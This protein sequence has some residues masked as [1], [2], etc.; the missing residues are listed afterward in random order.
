M[1]AYANPGDVILFDTPQATSDFKYANPTPLFPSHTT[2]HHST[3][4]VVRFHRD[5]TKGDENLGFDTNTV[6]IGTLHQ[7][8]GPVGITGAEAG[9]KIAITILDIE[10]K[11]WGWN[12]AAPNLGMLSDM[13]KEGKFNWWKPKGDNPAKPDAWVSDM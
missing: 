4:H 10:A 9:D 11:S 12:H 8:A 7:L 1:A 5:T 2:S 6:H 13:V 3:P